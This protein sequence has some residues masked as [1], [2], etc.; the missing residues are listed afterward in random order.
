MK[1]HSGLIAA[2][3]KVTMACSCQAE[4]LVPLIIML[5]RH[6]VVRILAEGQQCR[7]LQHRR[8]DRVVVRWEWK[9]GDRIF[10]DIHAA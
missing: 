2:G 10:R 3:E 8:G 4:V 9:D 5:P 7:V 6:H 1:H